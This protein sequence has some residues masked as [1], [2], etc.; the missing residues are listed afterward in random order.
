MA[1]EWFRGGA[2]KFG[3]NMIAVGQIKLIGRTLHLL[4]N[5]TDGKENIMGNDNS[6]LRSRS[7]DGISE[8]LMCALKTIIQPDCVINAIFRPNLFRVLRSAPPLSISRCVNVYVQR[9]I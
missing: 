6:S 5:Y 1:R 3:S 9:H 7:T 2:D 4:Y 8:S